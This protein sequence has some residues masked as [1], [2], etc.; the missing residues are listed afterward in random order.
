MGLFDKFNSTQNEDPLSISN[1]KEA[2]L[3]IILA[4][5]KAD[6]ELS[7]V[8]I[9]LV[10]PPFVRKSV[11]R[12]FDFNE[13]V[14]KIMSLVEV[15]GSKKMIDMC[16]PLLPEDHKATLYA[17]CIELAISDGDLSK[18]EQEIAEYLQQAMQLDQETASKIIEVIMIKSKWDSK[19]T[20]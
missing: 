20:E 7:E 4:V 2:W 3:G 13:A 12:D 11:L 10:A 6:G 1:Y 5:A 15:T 19:I 16:V 8:E 17:N 18:V 9:N 14:R